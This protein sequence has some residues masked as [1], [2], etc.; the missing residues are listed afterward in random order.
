MKKELLKLWQEYKQYL[1][2]NDM[3]EDSRLSFI[4]FMI[5]LED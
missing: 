4:A 5:W 2:D 1:I 3:M